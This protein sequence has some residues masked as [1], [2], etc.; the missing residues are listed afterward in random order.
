MKKIFYILPLLFFTACA[1]QYTKHEASLIAFKTPQMA[2]ADAGFIHNNGK[3]LKIVILVV[4]QPVFTLELGRKI[5]LDGSCLSKDKFIHERL[6]PH[7][8]RDILQNIFLGKEIFK[9]Q[10]KIIQEGGFKQRLF[11][12]GAYDIYYLV[13][14][15]QIRF[16]DKSA[17]ILIKTKKILQ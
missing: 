10:N 17:K 9:G 7:Y 3:D 5:C 14:N 6:S 2:F 4:G 11:K 12:A 1:P 16:K 8:P 15:G 13:Y